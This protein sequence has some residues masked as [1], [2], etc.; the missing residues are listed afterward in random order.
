MRDKQQKYRNTRCSNPYFH[1]KYHYEYQ[2][3][4]KKEEY[5][6]QKDILLSVITPKC[7]HHDN[8]G[9]YYLFYDLGD[10]S[11]HQPISENTFEKYESLEIVEIGELKTKGMDINE[12]ISCQFIK[13]V[14]QL[15]QSNNF[16][17]LDTF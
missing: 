3:K 1:D 10:C 4:L 11:F 6:N 2:Y 7:I 8:Q 15:I 9:N 17:Y 16:A 13:K 14:I 5:Y 12:L